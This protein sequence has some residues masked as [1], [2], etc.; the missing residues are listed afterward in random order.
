MMNKNKRYGDLMSWLQEKNILPMEEKVIQDDSIDGD[1]YDPG[2]ELPHVY[3]LNSLPNKAERYEKEDEKG[4]S[5][6]GVVSPFHKALKYRK[7]G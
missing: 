6:G 4:Y 2:M 5:M 1:E 7:K 3:K